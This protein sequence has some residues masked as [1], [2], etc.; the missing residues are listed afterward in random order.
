MASA[1]YIRSQRLQTL[2]IVWNNSGKSEEAVIHR[3]LQMGV[4][5]STALNYLETIKRRYP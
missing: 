5:K 4:V 2:L 3:A 1:G